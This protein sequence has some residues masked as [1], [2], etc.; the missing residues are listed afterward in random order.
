MRREFES[1]GL[2]RTAL[3]DDPVAQ[4]DAWFR[5]AQAANLLE[6]NALSLATAD[7]HGRPG[8][9][10]VLL[11][12]YDE[13]GFVFFTNYESTK[14]QALAAN[15]RAAMLFPWL[16]LNRQVVIEGHV[17]KIPDEQSQAYFAARPR[18]SRVGAWA[19]RQSQTID[20]REAL[21]QQVARESERFGEGEIP[22]P[23]FWGGY[24]LVPERFEFWQG[25]TSRLHDRFEYRRNNG[26][27]VIQRL[28]P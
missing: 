21:E 26:D 6:P 16:D 17:E 11:K 13:H 8:V 25:R 3:A 15:P 2:S 23:P 28:Q 20:S 14:A 4:F 22:R 27:W 12:A 24:R 7:G 19:S 9:R 5:Q 18:G 1:D 10:T